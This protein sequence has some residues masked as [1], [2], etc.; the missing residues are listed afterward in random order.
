MHIP[1]DH[2]LNYGV[3]DFIKPA[4]NFKRIVLDNTTA[5]RLALQSLRI[6]LPDGVLLT[7]WVVSNSARYP[8]LEKL[9]TE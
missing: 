4:I 6:P 7:E 5:F 8:A 1:Y 9:L 3:P 2:V